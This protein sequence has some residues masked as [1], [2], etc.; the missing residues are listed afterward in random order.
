MTRESSFRAWRAAEL[1]AGTHL[2]TR[3]GARGL[4]LSRPVGRRCYAGPFGT[5]VVNGPR[6]YEWASWVSDAVRPGHLF[7]SL[8]PSWN[9]RTPAESWLEVEARVSD[10]SLVWSRW[11][12]LGCWSE[13]DREILPT[14]RTGQDDDTARVRHDVL[15]ARPDVSWTGY[16][17]R[18]T[19]LRRPGSRSA[20]AVGLVG[21]ATAGPA[22]TDPVEPVGR[23]A[24]VGPSAGG[25]AHGV[26]LAVPAYSQQMHLGEYPQ[27]NSG[28]EAWC[29]PASTS[30]VLRHFG[31]GP[32][33]HE[34][35]WVEPG[36]PDRFVDHAARHVFDHAYNGAGNWSFNVAYAGRYGAE[37]FVTRLRSLAE[38]ERF[39]AAGIPLV[40]S[41]AF[42]EDEL[43]GAGYATLGHLLVIVGFGADGSVVC[44]DP[45]SHQL[46]DNDQVRVVY[47]RGQFERA[48][49]RS[50]G[51]VVY[52]VRPAHVPLPARVPGLPPNW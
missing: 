30:M 16:Q 22:P 35:A 27:W 28:G 20:P 26:E 51:G 44:N 11:Y 48:W 31:L 42:A 45:A 13:S 23:D 49:Q 10:D 21:A 46:P 40:A 5:A 50:A 19:L 43:D 52:V 14:S 36:F 32:D 1:A 39:V 18:V 37:A 25:V 41:V 4:A 8:V 34:Y 47:D 2:G 17:L 24:R 6:P 33:E 29:A 15:T 9:A 38:A 12:S 3:A 7:T